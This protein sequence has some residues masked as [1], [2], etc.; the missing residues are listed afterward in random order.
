MEKTNVKQPSG[1]HSVRMHSI[2]KK[3]IFQINADLLHFRLIK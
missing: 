1:Y 2:A 3:F